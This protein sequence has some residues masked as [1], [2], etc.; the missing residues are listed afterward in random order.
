[1]NC[2]YLVNSC[3]KMTL[4]D[5]KNKREY[6]R[7]LKAEGGPSS[8]AKE[9]PASKKKDDKTQK[10]SSNFSGVTETA[11]KLITEANKRFEKAEQ[12]PTVSNI[13]NLT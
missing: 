9:K 2:S 13:F 5:K 11:D 7:K 6:N 4:K 1:M 8:D 10:A 12:I 3:R